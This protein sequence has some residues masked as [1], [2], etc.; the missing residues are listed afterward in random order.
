MEVVVVGAGKLANAIL[1][2]DPGPGKIKLIKWEQ[3]EAKSGSSQAIIVHAGSGRQADEAINFCERSQS[4]FIEL[5][6]GLK[7]ETMTPSFPLII[8]PNTSI[9]LVKAMHLLNLSGRYFANEKIRII[10][11]HQESKFSAPGTAYKIAE[12]LNVPIAEIKSIRDREVQS[13]LIGIPDEFL[14]RHAYHKVV[15]GDGSEQITIETKVL[16]HESYA[17]GVRKIIQAV[18]TNNFEAKRYSILD[19]IDQ[20]LL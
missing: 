9:L 6:T 16:G 15:I 11:S 4:V 14:D 8:C 5:S 19:L 3:F 1:L 20:N 12:F 2:S 10:E 17:L 18:I 7:T 13:E